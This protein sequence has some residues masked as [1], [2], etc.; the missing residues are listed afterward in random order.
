V[1]LD[2]AGDRIGEFLPRIGGALLLLIVGLIVVRLLTRFLR[3]ALV[4]LGVDRLA[5]KAGAADVLAR[6]GLDR[7][8]SLLIAAALRIALSVAVVLAALSISG[9]DVLQDPVDR[10]VLFLP[11]LLA[12]LAIALGGLVLAGW[13]R[14]RA[15]RMAF[16]MDIGGPIGA[17]AQAAVLAIAA[18]MVL[19]QLGISTQ[20]LTVLAA[21][22][23]G[24]AALAL[25]LAFG[26]GSREV[27]RDISAGRYVGAT[28]HVGQHVKVAGTEGE[29][30]ALESAC[31]VLRS[32]DGRTL[33]VPHHLF[34]RDVVEATG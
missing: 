8:L 4:R 20:I 16:Q 13:V 14:E 18:I 1:I 12:A 27:A 33:R 19:A 6:G 17:L 7:S 10:A 31:A 5:E 26:L 29:I 11:Q 30:V 28:Y 21:I 24:G 9:L 34:L 32:A 15:D 23:A 3:R 25:A 2:S 22:A